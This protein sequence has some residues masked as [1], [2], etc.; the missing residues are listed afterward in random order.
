MKYSLRSLMIVVTLVG[1]YLGTYSAL[2][3]PVDIVD[4]GILGMVV[5]GYREPHFRCGDVTAKFIFA[6]LIWIDQRVRPA[7]WERFSDFDTP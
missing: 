3:Q 2:L 4:E 1:V 6:P 5:S 7:Y